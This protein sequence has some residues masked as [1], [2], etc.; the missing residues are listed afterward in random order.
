M[1]MILTLSVI[2]ICELM[3]IEGPT[4]WGVRLCISEPAQLGSGRPCPIRCGVLFHVAQMKRYFHGEEQ[5][6]R[7]LLLPLFEPW[8]YVTL[9][10]CP[11]R[12]P[13]A[14]F[15]VPRTLVSDRQVSDVGTHLCPR[16]SL[17]RMLSCVGQPPPPCNEQKSRAGNVAFFTSPSPFAGSGGAG[18]AAPFGS[19]ELNLLCQLVGRLV[20]HQEQMQQLLLNIHDRLNQPPG[21]MNH[22]SNPCASPQCPRTSTPGCVSDMCPQHCVNEVCAVH[23]ACGRVCALRGCPNVSP[24]E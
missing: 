6:T 5:A 24:P 17:S 20:Q 13:G 14:D 1:R 15:H 4:S 7:Q 10:A 19:R 9:D 11:Q 8:T 12:Q 23:Q 18:D 22:S 3:R 21:S 16:K 2:R